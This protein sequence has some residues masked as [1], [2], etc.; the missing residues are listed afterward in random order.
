MATNTDSPLR[1]MVYASLFRSPDRGRLLSG[2]SAPTGTDHP[3]NPFRRP[4]RRPFR[5]PPVH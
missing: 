2:H 3:A 1:R 4:G 5:R